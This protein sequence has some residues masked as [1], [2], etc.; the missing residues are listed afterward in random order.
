MTLGWMSSCAYS[1]CREREIREAQVLLDSTHTDTLQVYTD[2]YIHRQRTKANT[3]RKHCYRQHVVR[4]TA[5]QCQA[6][7]KMFLLAGNEES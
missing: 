1:S 3:L 2:I 5:E 7:L 4:N 6:M